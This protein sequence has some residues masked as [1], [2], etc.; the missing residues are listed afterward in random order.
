MLTRNFEDKLEVFD[1]QLK[2][3]SCFNG[4]SAPALELAI[5]SW[6]SGSFYCLMVLESKIWVLDVLIAPF[7]RFLMGMSISVIL[8][9][10]HHCILTVLLEDHLCFLVPVSKY[11]KLHLRNWP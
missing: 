2:F 3:F 10:S 8:P 6:S 11:Q 9:L 7:L 1:H 4:Y 5:S